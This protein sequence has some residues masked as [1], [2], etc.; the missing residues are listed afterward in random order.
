MASPFEG[1]H[2]NNST[3]GFGMQ[4]RRIR[5]IDLVGWMPAN[6]QPG[7]GFTAGP[8]SAGFAHGQIGRVEP[9]VFSNLR[10]VLHKQALLVNVDFAFR[11]QV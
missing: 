9:F 6:A 5:R 2:Y 4:S 3:A 1:T 8:R 11:T 10:E 7:T